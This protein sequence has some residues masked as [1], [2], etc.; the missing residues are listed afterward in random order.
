MNSSDRLIIQ[1]LEKFETTLTLSRALDLLPKEIYF[2]DDQKAD[3]FL[4]K[5]GS[6]ARAWCTAYEEPRGGLKFGCTKHRE[7]APTLKQAAIAM[8]YYLRKYELFS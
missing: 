6:A 4:W 8:L 3:L 5:T 7:F 1:E 2:G